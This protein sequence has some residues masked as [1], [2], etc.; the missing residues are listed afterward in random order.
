MTQ[1]EL[2]INVREV[3]P[4]L[5][6]S[7]Y[8]FTGNRHDAMDLFQDTMLAVTA[9]IDKFSDGTNFNA[10]CQT[11]LKNMFFNEW[12]KK[13][14][15]PDTLPPNERECGVSHDSSTM[16]LLEILRIVNALP[17][18]WCTV[19]KLRMFGYGYQEISDKLGIPLG[20]V[21]SRICLA[22]KKLSEDLREYLF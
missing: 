19:M 8:Y 16:E 12:R 14:S 20:T 4:A 17:R 11:I 15:R 22:R 7:A 5:L 1:S 21:K 10:W 18:P 2:A 6:R 9:N 3:T 13:V